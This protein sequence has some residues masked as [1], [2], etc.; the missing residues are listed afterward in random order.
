MKTIVTIFLAT[1]AITFSTLAVADSF[2]GIS[3]PAVEPAP[4]EY[5]AQALRRGEQGNVLVRYRVN[6]NGRAENIEVLES[7]N[8]MF[9]T[10]AVRAVR[11]SR[12]ARTFSGDQP[13]EVDGVVQRFEFVFDLND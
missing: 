9:N 5:P 13:V 2:E 10:A 6:E 3:V 4:V 8:R 7:S 1:I 11:E 12:Y